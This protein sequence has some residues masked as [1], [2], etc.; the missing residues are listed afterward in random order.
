MRIVVYMGKSIRITE[1]CHKRVRMAAAANGITISD[2]VQ[3]AISYY[4]PKGSS[5]ETAEQAKPTKK[6]GGKVL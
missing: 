4:L 5:N 2:L 3:E 6:K 1:S